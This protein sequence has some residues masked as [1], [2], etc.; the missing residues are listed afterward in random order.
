MIITKKRHKEILKKA[1]DD[2]KRAHDLYVEA[3]KLLVEGDAAIIP[4]YWYTGVEVTKPYVDRTF[5]RGGANA[6][7]KWTMD[8]PAE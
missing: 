2:Q 6:W 3:E 5:G 1:L 7:E 4:L 8:K